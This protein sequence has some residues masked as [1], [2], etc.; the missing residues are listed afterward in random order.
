MQDVFKW[1][2]HAHA[3][4]PSGIRPQFSDRLRDHNIMLPAGA[5]ER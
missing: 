5:F 2:F 4:V 1:D 3:V